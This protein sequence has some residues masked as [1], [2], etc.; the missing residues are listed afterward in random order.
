MRYIIFSDSHSA[1]APMIKA[2]KLNLES[3][4]NGIIFLGDKVKD[5]KALK[6]AFP[7]LPIYPVMGNCDFDLDSGES[8]PT[9]RIIV[10]EGVR[11]LAE[12]GHMHFVKGDLSD[13][14]KFAED[15]RA[16]VYLFGHTHERF[17]RYYPDK[18]KRGLWAFNPGS[19]CLP[20]DGF[21]SFG[22]LEIRD[23]QVLLS[24]GSI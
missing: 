8:I 17:E 19:I 1:V 18:G 16:D 11:I 9:E 13:A 20:R 14:L 2:V 5:T 12:H 23:G 15:N 10:A 6:E 24:H 21:Y 7:E 3:G 4:L 22:L